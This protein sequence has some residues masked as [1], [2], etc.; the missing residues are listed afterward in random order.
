MKTKRTGGICVGWIVA[1]MIGCALTASADWDEGG[2]HKMHFP[3]LPELTT[4][5]ID[6]R[7]MEPYPVAD[8]WQCSESGLVTGIHVWVSWNGD[9][10]DPGAIFRLGIWSD[11]PVG[12]GNPYSQP[13]NLLWQA[14]FGNADYVSRVY[15]SGVPEWFY[16]PSVPEA[17]PAA[18]TNCW[19]YNFYIPDG[20][21]TQEVG[22]IYWLSMECIAGVGTAAGWKTSVD[23]FQ[24]SAVW[25]GPQGNWIEL[26]APVGHPRAGTPL[27]L[28]F[29][30]DGHPGGQQENPVDY[31]AIEFP[32]AITTAVPA[33]VDIY[34]RVY[35]AG[36]TEPAGQGPGIKAQVGYGPD[37]SDPAVNPGWTWVAAAYESDLGNDDQYKGT[38]QVNTAG[39]YDYAYRFSYNGSSWLYC[40]M[41][42]GGSADGYAVSDA[43]DLVLYP[44]EQCQKWMQLP[45]CEYGLDLPSWGEVN[46]GEQMIITQY[47]VADDWLCDGRPITSIGWWGSYVGRADS[48]PPENPQ[49]GRPTFFLLNWY[50][51][52]PAGDP[53]PL[54]SRP[55][56][57]IASYLAVLNDPGIPGMEPGRVSE[58]DA[59]T[60]V[61]GARAEKE[62]YYRVELDT[63]WIEKEGEIYWLSIEAL[64]D[65]AYPPP[66]HPWGWAT[67]I[68]LD[69]IDDAVVWQ[70][71]G[72]MPPESWSEMIWPEYPYEEFWTEWE[73]FMS[74]VETNPSV[75][76][77]Y[78]LF[79]DVCPRRVK[80]WEQ[81]PDMDRGTDLWSWKRDGEPM[82]GDVVR[83][84]DFISD[85]RRITDIHWWGSYSNWMSDVWGCETNPVPPPS[86]DP[87][88]TNVYPQYVP[89]GFILSWHTNSEEFAC[90]PGEQITEAFVPIELCR[91][92]YYGTVTQKWVTDYQEP[93]YYEHEY[94][95][96]VDLWDVDGPWNEV[97]GGHYWLDIEA[98]FPGNFDPAPYPHGGWGWKVTEDTYT[99]QTPC[100]SVYSTD[101]GMSW[102]SATFP[103]GHPREMDEVYADLAFELTTDEIST[104]DPGGPI[105]ITNIA[106]NTLGG[107]T[108]KSVGTY[109][110]GYHSLQYCTNLL[111]SNDW[112]FLETRTAVFTPPQENTWFVNPAFSNAFYRIHEK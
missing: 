70:A 27:S 68:E 53:E 78:E 99:N 26:L 104:N 6:V 55:G 108:L 32:P 21:I 15:F 85:G 57:Q 30:I 71:G 79:T 3:Q 16:D 37:G 2:S 109:G 25:F 83:A 66:E 12:Q 82:P 34:G 69:K 59:C 5:G 96:Y 72:A 102:V 47:R 111:V 67:S 94:Q 60:V 20:A 105:V 4:D 63:P 29:V 31:G 22:T 19:Q 112:K 86:Q 54:Y 40:D 23:D 8:D 48:L 73:P 18:D 39:R 38:L 50:H 90:Q 46:L 110:G 14:D 42:P 77:A 103:P 62:Y 44:Q 93:W 13:S 64:Y 49:Q 45:D 89:A 106:V 92:V 52:I 88:V 87:A 91:E 98:V 61:K 84:D 95:Y 97:K 76:M 7:V 58:V 81:P 107:Y 1:G 80:K 28:A 17:S 75:N 9:E 41:Y 33:K 43:G 10:V 56:P 24:D 11:W 35:E 100:A 36:V 65:T 51:D 101:G 74:M